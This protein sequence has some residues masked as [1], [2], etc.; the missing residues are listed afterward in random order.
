MGIK[1]P[2]ILWFFIKNWK[3]LVLFV[4]VDVLESDDPV[5]SNKH[6]VFN[7]HDGMRQVVLGSLAMLLE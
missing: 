4:I 7:L 6:D 2:L 1:F 3:V 5:F